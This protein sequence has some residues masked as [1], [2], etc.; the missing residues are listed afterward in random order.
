MENYHLVPMDDD[1]KHYVRAFNQKINKDGLWSI[2]I[3]GCRN[4]KIM[5]FVERIERIWKTTI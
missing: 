4:L 1:K 5:D 2:L 3:Q